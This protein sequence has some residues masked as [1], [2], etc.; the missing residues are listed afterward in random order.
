M[1]LL[2]YSKPETSY[3]RIRWREKTEL[4]VDGEQMVV[5]N[6]RTLHP[7]YLILY[8]SYALDCKASLC[9]PLL[10]ILA[11]WSRDG[12][13]VPENTLYRKIAVYKNS[14]EAD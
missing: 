13:H 11:L 3:Y 4:V 12:K 1:S 14:L 5:C 8:P 2:S 6:K 10:R 7:I 9:L